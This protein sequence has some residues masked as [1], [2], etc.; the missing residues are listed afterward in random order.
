MIIYQVF[1][2]L[3]G[4]NCQH[5]VHNGSLQENGCGK[6]ADFSAKALEEIRSLGADYIWYTGLIEHATQTDYSAFGIRPDHPAVV[7]GRAGSPYAIKDYFDIDPDLATK[8]ERRMAEFEN[9]V[10]RT[11]KA[12]LRMI[13]DFVP[14]HVARQYHSDSCPNGMKDIGSQDDTSLHFSTHNNFYYF[15]GQAL[16]ADFPLDGYEETP[17]RVSG[18]DVFSAH[19]GRN[20]WYETVKLN[21]GVDY[22]GGRVGHFS[23]VPDTWQ[24]MLGILLFWASKGVD[25]F[26]CDMAEMVP[27]EFWGWAIPQVKEQH[28]DIIFI[29]EVYNPAE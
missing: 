9:L 8:V 1:T 21:Y 5:P 27:V 3:F 25:G 12:G 4:G 18:N 17:A 24:K 6:L 20:D 16:S 15:P 13:I 23:P 19:V 2:R 26:R 29:A 7:K 11:H 10:K 22:C 28:P 14:N